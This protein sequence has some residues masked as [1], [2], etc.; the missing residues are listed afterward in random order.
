MTWFNGER[1]LPDITFTQN[2]DKVHPKL[3]F[4]TNPATFDTKKIRKSINVSKTARGI[5]KYYT[6]IIGNTSP[7]Q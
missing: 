3:Q 2:N 1:T 4:S 5:G 6:K 7:Q